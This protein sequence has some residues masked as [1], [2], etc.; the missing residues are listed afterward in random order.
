MSILELARPEI[1]S[2]KAY[3]PAARRAN[4]V[5]LNANESPWP[6][7]GVSPLLNRYPESRSATLTAML[8][9][10]FGVGNDH[11]LVTRGSDDAIDLLVR[12]FCIAGTDSIMAPVPGFGM[13]ALA[14]RIQGANVIDLQLD[15]AKSFAV[16]CDDVLDAWRPGC[17]LVFLCSPNNPTGSLMP[18]KEIETICTAL[19]GKSLVVLD[20]A[21]IEFASA[22]SMVNLV[23]EYSNLVV[24]R[25]M[26]KAHALAASRVG[27]LVA[28]PEVVRLLSPVL[29]PYPL[30][31][32]SQKRAVAALRPAARAETA[33]CINRTLLERERLS[34]ALSALP[35]VT[36]V[37]PSEGN[38]VLVQTCG[39][40]AFLRRCEDHQVLIRDIS[41]DGPLRD[42]VR[43]TVGTS[44]ENAALLSALSGLANA[45]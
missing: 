36:R 17:K 24:L 31:A 5:R 26:S 37:W 35:S 45:S 16:T 29:P 7:M 6:R 34:R 19:A 12:A 32:D 3:S 41:D 15:P 14:A 20:E 40:R 33:K 39:A 30:P 4:C 13:Y 11:V 1:R 23:R 2:L 10:Y 38:F 25:T 28:S 9:D 42:C 21:Y 22:A 44:E 27:A 43:V 18:R 8:A